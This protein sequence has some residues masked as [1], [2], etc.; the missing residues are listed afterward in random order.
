MIRLCW[1][2]GFFQQLSATGLVR[3]LESAVD[4][5]C[6]EHKGLCKEA[7]RGAALCSRHTSDRR[8]QCPHHRLRTHQTPRMLSPQEEADESEGI[9]SPS[10]RLIAKETEHPGCGRETS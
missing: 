6:P 4:S 1:P 3:A 8:P 2:L 5:L 10:L 9:L 7:Q